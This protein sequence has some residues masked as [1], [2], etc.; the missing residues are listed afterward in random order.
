[1]NRRQLREELR[2]CQHRVEALKAAGFSDQALRLA[3]I[4]EEVAVAQEL[5]HLEAPPE[6]SKCD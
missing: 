2:R 6:D 1:M 4:Y 5:L 3:G